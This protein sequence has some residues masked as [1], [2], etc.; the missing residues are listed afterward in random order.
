MLL[1]PFRALVY[2][3][4]LAGWLAPRRLVVAVALAAAL[5]AATLRLVPRGGRQLA[6]WAAWLVISQLVTSNLFPQETQYD[7]RFVFLGSLAVPA[8]AALVASA[9]WDRPRMRGA[10]VAVGVA[11]VAVCAAISVARAATYRDPV[12]FFAQWARTSPANGN[13]RHVLGTA[14]ARAGRGEEAEREL[15]E[16]VRL[17]PGLASAH[18]NLAVLLAGDGRLA[19]AA[20]SFAAALRA[21]PLDADAHENLAVVLRRLGREGEALGHEREAARLRARAAGS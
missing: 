18:Y 17:E 1:T 7:E 19:E 3:P 5:G 16:A 8:L 2:E 6:F 21:D 4:H 10:C 15:R 14:L 9:L 11:C 12:T 13:A 20:E